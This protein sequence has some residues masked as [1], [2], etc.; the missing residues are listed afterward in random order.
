MRRRP[1]T[2]RARR[3]G[4]ARGTA[5][6]GCPARPGPTAASR[7]KVSGAAEQ[8]GTGAVGGPGAAGAGKG[9]PGGAL[10][11]SLPS[12]RQPGARRVR[13]G[14]QGRA[15]RPLQGEPDAPARCPAAGDGEEACE[16]PRGGGGP[17]GAELP[18]CLGQ[19]Q[20]WASCLPS[21]R[22]REGGIE[23]GPGASL[24]PGGLSG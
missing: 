16:R 9:S 23:P 15:R 7:A 5:L 13:R 17:R 8:A 11:G 20:L 12:A 4:A 14:F 10:P 6:C 18:L 24:P 2:A 21:Q 1:A 3:R 22:G 19:A